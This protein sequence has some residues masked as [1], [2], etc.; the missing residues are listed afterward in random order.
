MDDDTL[1]SIGEL[2]RLTGLTVKTIR[3]WSDAG[4]VPPTDRTPAGY[5][6]Y[7]PEALARLGLVRTLRD[8][9]I[10]LA[11]IQ[12]VLGREVTV[13]EVAAAHV[14]A[15]EV[16]IRTLRLRQGVLRA[17]AG[18]G[19]TPEE[20]ELMHR[21]AKLSD[22]ERHRLIHDFIDTTFGGLDVDAEFLAMMRTAM[23]E[24]PEDPTPEQL[25][26]WVELAELVQDDGFRARMR[27]AAADQ[28]QARAEAGP[29][30]DEAAR[31]VAELIRE[32]TG[33]ARDAG[34]E[35]GSEAARE[36][37]DQIVGACAR[38]TGREDGPEFRAWLLERLE[39][40][41][42]SGYER[43]WRLIAVINGRPADPG[44]EPAVAWLVAGVRAGQK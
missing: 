16:Q 14:E 3:F 12:Q 32:R 25:N 4:V 42:D 29:F 2:A 37:V 44:M 36:V 19:S 35:P 1:L 22:Q 24:L 31:R 11:T 30:A 10:D 21:L 34:I 38:L 40:A 41:R 5:R 39:I 7:G 8:L 9:G 28:V 13:A 20:M 17:A 27:H 33:A 6:L 43:Y 26:A 23:P 15:L 18:R